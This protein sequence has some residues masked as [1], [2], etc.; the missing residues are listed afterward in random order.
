[1]RFS[2][3]HI[4]R[5]TH[6]THEHTHTHTCVTSERCENCEKGSLCSMLTL[7]AFFFFFIFCV[8]GAATAT[9]TA[10]FP[11]LFCWAGCYYCE[12]ALVFVARFVYDWL[13]SLMSIVYNNN[14]PARWI[15]SLLP[16]SGG[17]SSRLTSFDTSWKRRK[18]IWRK[19]NWKWNENK[20]RHSLAH[21]RP[22]PSTEC[23]IRCPIYTLLTTHG[24]ERGAREANPLCSVSEWVF[25]L[26]AL[27]SFFFVM[28]I[29]TCEFVFGQTT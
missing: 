25:F 1:M 26:S 5:T 24:H 10:F 9:A 16:S 17:R 14:I 23:E 15:F 19:K 8:A 11:F 21:I 6:S 2:A 13:F 18:Y 29:F 28:F 27:D 12:Y 20:K 4:R 3:R 7:M 22:T